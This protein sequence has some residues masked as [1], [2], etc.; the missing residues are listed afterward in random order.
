MATFVEDHI[1]QMSFVVN[2]SAANATPSVIGA[3]GRTETKDNVKVRTVSAQAPIVLSAAD[4]ASLVT[5][6]A[7]IEKLLRTAAGL[8]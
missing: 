5:L 8:P 1:G 4:Q 3:T 6:V 7:S 2:R